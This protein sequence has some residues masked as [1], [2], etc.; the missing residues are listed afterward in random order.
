MKNLLVIFIIPFI[1]SCSLTKSK[2]HSKEDYQCTENLKFKN[3][4]FKNINYIDS[5]INKEQNQDFHKSLEFISTYT[6]VSYETML[7]YNRIYPYGA[8]IKDKKNWLNWY[9][10]NKCKNLKL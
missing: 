5:L 2:I 7:N 8:Y 6:H 9:E 1:F 3:E 10:E 4:F